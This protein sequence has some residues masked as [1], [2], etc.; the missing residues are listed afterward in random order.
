[1]NLDP[2]NEAAYISIAISGASTIAASND[3]AAEFYVPSTT[4]QGTIGK[5][6]IIG[7]LTAGTN[8]FKMQY[9]V[10]TGTVEFLRRELVVTGIA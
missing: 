4:A 10:N 8:T 1:M 5:T 9:R 2:A 3:I 6:L 7:G